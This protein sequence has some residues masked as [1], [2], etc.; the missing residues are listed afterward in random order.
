MK[1]LFTLLL[2]ACVAIACM[3]VPARPV[4]VSVKQPDGKTLTFI[5]RGDEHHRFKFT[6]DG[7]PIVQGA[8]NAYYYAVIEGD[9]LICS[10]VLAH[11]AEDRTAEEAAFVL[12]KQADAVE[13]LNTERRAAVSR[14]QSARLRTRGADA[15]D[16]YRGTPVKGKY[17]MLIILAEYADVKMSVPDVR[18]AFADC[19]N[20]EGYCQN[21]HIGSVRDYFRDQSYGVFELELDV[22]GPVSLSKVMSYYGKNKNNNDAHPAEMV[23]EACRLA[24]DLTDFS[25]YDWDGDGYV[26]QVYVIYAGYNEA[27]YG[28]D[29]TIW[30]HAYDL[31]SAQKSNGDG[32]GMLTIDGVKV[33]KYACSSELS[34]NEGTKMSSIGTF[35]HEFGHCLGLKDVYDVN[36]GGGFGMNSW[37]VMDTGNYNGPTGYGE[38][39]CGYTA[40]ERWYLGW[41][42]YKVLSSAESVRGMPSLDDEPVAYAIVNDGH[43]SEYFTL[44]N[45][46]NRGWYS[47]VKK[48]TTP[49]G[50][51]I[52]HIDFSKSAWD[53]NTV[54]TNV[55]HQRIALVPADNSFG[56]K[57]DSSGNYDYA[58][59]ENDLLGD[60]FP[61]SYGVTEFTDT[62]HSSSGG[63]WYNLNENF[64]LKPGKPITNITEKDGLISFDF[65]GGS[66][67]DIA[68]PE[69]SDASSYIIYNVSGKQ[70]SSMDAPGVYVIK[71]G[72]T[73]RKVVK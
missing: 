29:N 69:S 3:A 9:S 46:Q 13:Q 39:P 37:D 34:S 31:Y 60:P 43:P 27:E 58:L 23:A 20:K 52:S 65:M 57:S 4:P 8:G 24:E 17:K 22:V 1:Y 49:H 71:R 55:S 12:E 66:P 15:D 40:F 59:T 64:S 72:D 33:N 63:K 25:Q 5:L 61:G 50:M 56:K 68:M 10:S 42:D 47:Y 73:V 35:C 32:P 54:N 45:R 53:N 26:D 7:M 2:T 6:T 44:E 51:L 36:Y 14:A 41:L 18:Q 70:V 48:Y 62:S 21:G 19:Y 30:P 28:G 38:V 11:N 16:T 67:D